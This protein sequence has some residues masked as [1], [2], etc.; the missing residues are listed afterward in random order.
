MIN[1][2]TTKKISAY[3]ILYII[4]FSIFSIAGFYLGNKNFPD[5]AKSF[6]LPILTYPD[7][8][9]LSAKKLISIFGESDA[10]NYVSS[11]LFLVKNGYFELWMTHLWP[12]G[13]PLITA[14]IFKLFGESAYPLKMFYLTAATW[15]LAFVLIYH[16]LTKIKNV[17]LKIILTLM[18]LYFLVFNT[19]IFVYGIVLSETL[20]L[21]LFVIAACLFILWLQ[22]HRLS[23]LLWSIVVFAMLSYFR[24]FF[25]LFGNFLIVLVIFNILFK[26]TKNYFTLR[27]CNPELSAQNTLKLLFQK[28]KEILSKKILSI[29]AAL[30]VFSILL[31]P[32]RIYNFT[33]SN[34]FAWQSM[35]SVIW[36][37]FWAPKAFFP[38]ANVAC[39]TQPEWCILLSKSDPNQNLFPYEFYRGLTLITF[40]EDPIKWYYIKARH[41]NALWFGCNNIA[42]EWHDLLKHHRLALIEGSI[43]FLIGIASIIVSAFIWTELFLF[44]TIFL[45]FNFIVFTFFHYEPRYSL[46][47]QLFFIYLPLWLWCAKRE[48]RLVTP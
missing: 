3:A 18:P 15:A 32:W 22:N 30:F 45:I 39:E 44:S 13:Q 46:F 48:F 19:W 14:A 20:T 25:E 40:I 1:P 33:H 28:R 7:Y 12:P 16:S 6:N 2:N 36:P 29:I 43:I 38:T 21:P 26:I 9:H 35:G 23:Y 10:A 27:L 8:L 34:T 31:L 37:S 47:L 24:G 5:F 42:Y 17:L 4:F 11:A 41:F